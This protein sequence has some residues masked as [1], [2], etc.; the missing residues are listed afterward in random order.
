M[1]YIRFSISNPVKVTVAVLLLLLFGLIGLFTIPIQLT[2]NVDQPIITVETNWTGRSPEEVERQ[3]IE[4]QEDKL[5]SVTNLRKMTATAYQGRSNI[6]LEFYV[7]TNMTRVLQEVSDKLREVPEYPQDVDQPVIT[8]SEAA[9]EKAIAWFVLSSEDPNFD[10]A[11]VYDDAD[12]RM[13]PYLERIEGLSRVNIYGGREH[14]VH[15]Q[16]D[17]HRLAQRGITFNQLR[18]ALQLENVNIS[19]GDLSE[20]RLDWRVRTVGQYEDLDAVRNTIVKYGPGGPIRIK[21][22]AEVQL[23]LQ[24]RRAFVHSNGQE[25]MAINCIR[26]TGS[27][28]MAVMREVR[29][30]VAEIN[31]DILPT[32]GPKLSLHQVYDETIYIDDALRL[33]TD[34]L[35]Q[36]GVLVVL[37]LLLFLRRAKSPALVLVAMALMVVSGTVALMT[38][39]TVH[40]V[41][42]A[43]VVIGMAIIALDSPPTTI[44]SLAIPLSIIGT[45]V[46]L[47]AFGRNL[48]VVS[49][50]GLAF[51]VGMVVDNAVVVLE[52]IDRHMGLGKSIMGA[53]Y[54]GA[55]EVGLAI[56]AS[57]A[58]TLVV[59]IPVLTLKEEVGQLFLDI[60]LA[61]CAAVT[62]SLL[63]S[64]TVIPSAAARWLHVPTETEAHEKFNELWGITSVLDRL[65]TRVADL[66]YWLCGSYLWRFVIVGSFTVGSLVAAWLLMPPTTYLPTGN[67]NFVFGLMLTPPGYNIEQNEWIAR[68]VESV[69]RPYWEAE[70][71]EDTAKLPPVVMDMQT[72]QMAQVPPID[73]FFFVSW[74]GNIFMGAASGSKSVV[75]PLEPLMTGAMMQVPGAFGFAQQIALFG[76]GLGGTNSL[77]VELIGDDLGHLRQG[78]LALYQQLMGR[79]GIQSV[80]PDPLNFNLAGPELQIKIDRVRAA[81][82][83]VDVAS[84]GLGVQALVDGATVGDFRYRGDAIDLVMVRDPRFPLTPDLLAQIPVAISQS[85]GGGTVPL[86]SIASIENTEAPQQIKRVEQRRA[87]T[88]T[89][90]PPENVPLEQATADIQAMIQPLRQSGQV[91]PDVEVRMAGTADKLVQVREAF[92]GQWH[93]FSLATFRSLIMSRMF[94][95]FLINYLVMVWLFNSFLHPLVILF[96]IP[97]ATVGGFLGLRV[98]HTFVQSQLLDLVTMLG[99]IVLMGTVV[100]NAILVVAQSL[101]FM[102][103][104]GESPEDRLAKAL[105][106]R[107]A[108]RES[109]RTRLRPVFMTA[110][111]TVAGMLPLVIKPGAGSE[112]YRGM[113]SV[114]V[115]G[116]IVATLFTLL[117]VPLLFSLVLDLKVAVYRRIGWRLKELNELEELPEA[118]G[119][120][121]VAPTSVAANPN[122]K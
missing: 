69:I 24:K 6:E 14:E 37:V 36:G 79:Y 101:N 51:A 114:I 57:T 49:L 111:T 15:I 45:F 61:I 71:F 23:T 77:D 21:D 74:S 80:R 97:L 70:S 120:S 43:G 35:W 84:M 68:R 105:P 72:G 109:V 4:E 52:N 73:T 47:V 3:I 7:G 118:S 94:L 59:F 95:A 48:N 29:Q 82:L 63:V 100:N 115:G 38:A 83:G 98:V 22:L 46:V 12:R 103:G 104:F 76:R 20:G 54:D 117:V 39:G 10:V 31:R 11:S 2:P 62:L 102:Q 56:L 53:A 122:G 78:A 18:Q 26:E 81:D 64:V 27:N 75:K 91:S 44:I 121:G 106:P 65:R 92:L 108:I 113:G 67:R 32:M 85:V 87:I 90:V 41:A 16:V 8:A 50:A 33:V 89:V 119:G 9:E 110:T 13:K 112:L 17:P 40:A 99:F 66:V 1:D 86:S 25:A 19:G 55:R 42:I 107:E 34:N 60:S 5:K 58:T 93:G 96:T 88:L 28:V 116:F 30:R